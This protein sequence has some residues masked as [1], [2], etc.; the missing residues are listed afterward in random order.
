MKRRIFAWT[1]V[2]VLIL[3]MSVSAVESRFITPRPSLTFSG[4][5]AT[6][7]IN[8]RADSSSDSISVTV[9]LWQGSTCLQTWTDSSTN[10]LFFSETYSKG[11]TAG[12]T[13]KMTVSYTIAGK[14]YPQ[15]ETSATCRG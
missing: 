6:C 11:I 2:V 12:K 1:A 8:I 10:Y 4:T 7:A 15:V 13:Y 14:S 5:T 9:K 3:S